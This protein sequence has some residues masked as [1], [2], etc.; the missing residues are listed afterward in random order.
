MTS[1]A[2]IAPMPN[3]AGSS[4]RRSRGQYGI[5]WVRQ[6]FPL[7]QHNWS[8][9]AAV[10]ARY[11]DTKNAKLGNDYRDSVFANQNSIETPVQLQ[12]FTQKFA[13]S[14]GTALPFA[15][16]PMG[17]LSGLVK[18]DRDLGQR[19]GIEH[20]PTIWVVTDGSHAAPFVEVVDRT[21]TNSTSSSTRLSLIRADTEPLFGFRYSAI[22]NQT[23]QISQ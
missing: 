10:K 5:P 21:P 9:Q 11:F 14:H 18:A 6:D 15:I 16:D 22:R 23:A 13:A 4:C 3:S 12:Q 2:L 1:S 7:P 19:I 20:T 8:F 17:K